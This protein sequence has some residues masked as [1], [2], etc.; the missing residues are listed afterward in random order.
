MKYLVLLPSNSWWVGKLKTKQAIEINFRNCS[1]SAFKQ[2]TCLVIFGTEQ[3]NSS[4]KEFQQI[5]FQFS[6]L[7]TKGQQAFL[8]V[9][10]RKLHILFIFVLS[11]K[12]R[13]S[14]EWQTLSQ[15]QSIWTCA[16][17]RNVNN[18]ELQKY[19]PTNEYFIKW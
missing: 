12:K 15:W 16:I 6:T 17:T 13:L 9:E 4:K 3:P 19:Y 1:I 5:Q 14:S 2:T 11:S 8:I 7:I 18:K 10:Q